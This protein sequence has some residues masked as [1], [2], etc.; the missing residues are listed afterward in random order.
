M[1]ALITGA[2][3]GIGLSL[4]KELAGRGYDHI[5]SSAGARL[6]AAGD[7]LR[8][9]G[10]EVTEVREDLATRKG[11]NSLWTQTKALSP[12]IDIAC[13]NAGIVGGGIFS[14]PISMPN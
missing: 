1:R 3:S 11:V 12:L 7:Q 14:D 9:T 8:A 4:A 13:I 6:A 2:S 10:I 5:V